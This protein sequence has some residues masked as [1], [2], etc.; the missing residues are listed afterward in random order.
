MSFFPSPNADGRSKRGG[1]ARLPA[2]LDQVSFARSEFDQLDKQELRRE[3]CREQGSLCVH[4][5]RKIIEGRPVL[6]IDRWR[7]LCL[8]PGLA[9][10]GRNL[11]LSC[12]SDE[13]RAS[14]KGNRRHRRNADEV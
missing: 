8:N 9:L 10:R 3:I 12:P 11:C 13:T 14:A 1:L 6:R 5:E 2:V 7:P 4:C